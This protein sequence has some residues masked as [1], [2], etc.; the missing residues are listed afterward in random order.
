[1]AT[2]TS[3]DRLVSGAP[4]RQIAILGGLILTCGLV[5]VITGRRRR[6]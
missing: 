5:L 6:A 1:M 3:Q 2:A 4:V